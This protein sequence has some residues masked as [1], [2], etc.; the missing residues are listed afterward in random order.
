MIT[1][2]LIEDAKAA[3]FVFAECNG[4]IHVGGDVYIGDRLAKFAELQRQRDRQAVPSI[5][6]GKEQDAF[7]QWA[8][9]E[10]YDLSTHPL[11]WLFLD[12]K[13][14]AAR[15]GW[16]AALRYVGQ[17]LSAAPSPELISPHPIVEENKP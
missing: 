5:C 14:Y 12:A 11:H 4:G 7:E 13:T 8:K 16:K 17:A 1:K 10:Q 15:Q 2:E 9:V 3:G 6:D